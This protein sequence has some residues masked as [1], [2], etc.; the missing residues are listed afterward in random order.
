M[1]TL[2]RG[3]ALIYIHIYSRGGGGK[4]YLAS[5]RRLDIHAVVGGGGGFCGVLLASAAAP[6]RAL[7]RLRQL[8]RTLAG[9]DVLVVPARGRFIERLSS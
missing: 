3:F 5:T 6:A 8:A 9:A 4:V 1:R 2:R 7:P